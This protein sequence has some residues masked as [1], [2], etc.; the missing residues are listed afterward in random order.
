ML[1]LPICLGME[2]IKLTR[3]KYNNL[4]IPLKVRLILH[5]KICFMTLQDFKKSKFVLVSD[6]VT[7]YIMC[8][9][10]ISM[11]TVFFLFSRDLGKG[12]IMRLHH[13]ARHMGSVFRHSSSSRSFSVL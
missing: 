7:F 6:L 11:V 4:N 9:G 10:L 13:V 3:K 2:K 8:V 5:K 1:Q 12:L